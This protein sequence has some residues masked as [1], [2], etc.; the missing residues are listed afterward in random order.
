MVEEA[1][2]QTSD[3]RG[4]SDCPILQIRK[5]I[6]EL[7]P[8]AHCVP[9]FWWHKLPFLLLIPHSWLLYLEGSPPDHMVS[10]WPNMWPVPDKRQKPGD[11]SAE[12]IRNGTF[13]VVEVAKLREEKSQAASHLFSF[14]CKD[15][16]QECSHHQGRMRLNK[17]GK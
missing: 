8:A 9:S 17:G 13:S 7:T 16:D 2:E 10:S 14:S 12:I 3:P 4:R 5:G 1:S 11:S 15:P 6:R